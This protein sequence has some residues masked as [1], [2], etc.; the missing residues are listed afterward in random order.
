MPTRLEDRV[1]ALELAMSD[2]IKLEERVA[3]LES[4]VET[5]RVQLAEIQPVVTEFETEKNRRDDASVELGARVGSIEKTVED[6]AGKVEALRLSAEQYQAEWPKVGSE[7][8]KGEGWQVAG[9][10]KRQVRLSESSGAAGSNR[11]VTWG[12]QLAR[13]GDK[14]LVM[15]DSL[16]RGVG[17]KMKRQFDDVFDVRAVG[18]SKLG[19]VSQA[20]KTLKKTQRETWWLLQGQT[21]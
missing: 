21:A 17:Y 15:G 18:G 10:G 7:G 19:Q 9:R 4:T 20:A 2:K 14:V 5:L 11:K 6:L 12:E 8:G 1:A 3:A 13:T 16:A